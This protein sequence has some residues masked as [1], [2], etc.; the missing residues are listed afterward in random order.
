MKKIYLNL[1]ILKSD[2]S[3]MLKASK[4]Q[5]SWNVIRSRVLEFLTAESLVGI[6]IITNYLNLRTQAFAALLDRLHRFSNVF[7]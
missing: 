5:L 2:I 4:K 3:H 7:T 6:N 1:L